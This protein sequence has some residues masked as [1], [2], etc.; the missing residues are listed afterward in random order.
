MSLSFI[1]LFQ[2]LREYFNMCHTQMSG[3]WVIDI[4]SNPAEISMSVFLHRAI[5]DIFLHVLRELLPIVHSVDLHIFE[6]PFL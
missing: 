2:I 3:L 4:K 6:D 1:L 5:P